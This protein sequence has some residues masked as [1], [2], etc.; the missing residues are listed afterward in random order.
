MTNCTNMSSPSTLVPLPIPRSYITLVLLFISE[1]RSVTDIRTQFLMGRAFPTGN[2]FMWR[3]DSVLCVLRDLV[4]LRKF[5]LPE[6]AQASNNW[7]IIAAKI[8]GGES[9]PMVCQS[10][11]DNG[12]FTPPFFCSTLRSTRSYA[13][14]N[15]L[16]PGHIA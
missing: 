4:A 15:K 6:M 3:F 16:K 8:A 13:N 10:F 11:S 2:F 1:T 5:L 9:A 12:L 7:N 14:Q